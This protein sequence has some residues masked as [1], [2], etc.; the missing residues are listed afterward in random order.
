MQYCDT[1]ICNVAIL[2]NY[3]VEGE[4]AHFST[5]L[6][7]KGC[8]K[9]NN[10]CLWTHQYD[11]VV[12]WPKPKIWLLLHRLNFM[13]NMVWSEDIFFVNRWNTAHV[14]TYIQNREIYMY[15]TSK[16]C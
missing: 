7:K 9:Y 10:D 12:L 11:I 8:M 6:R 1:T 3:A 5:P 13:K 16:H 15:S 2:L 14:V 4:V